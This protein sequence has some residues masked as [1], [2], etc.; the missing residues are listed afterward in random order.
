MSTTKKL[1]LGPLPKTESVK[2]TFPCPASLKADL[3][4][5]AALHSQTYGEAVDAVTL[6][7]ICW[8]RSWRG[9]RIQEEN[10]IQ[11]ST[12][13]QFNDMDADQAAQTTGSGFALPCWGIVEVLRD[14]QIHKSASMNRRISF[15]YADCRVRAC[16]LL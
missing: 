8:R 1:R 3:D 11:T 13:N 12:L 6:I 14:I 9:S 2:M 5:Y 4:R 16:D 15:G 7:P 10:Q